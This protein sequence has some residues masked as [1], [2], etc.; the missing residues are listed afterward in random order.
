[1]T[2]SIVFVG[3]S[4]NDPDLANLMREVTARLQAKPP[5]H[6]AIMSYRTDAD[7]DATR[8]RMEGKFG[9]SPV[10]F[11]RMPTSPDGDDYSNLVPLLE[12]LAGR[13]LSSK[14]KLTKNPNSVAAEFDPEDPHKGRFG[15]L[16]E[17]SGRRVSVEKIRGS[18]AKGY[19]RVALTIAAVRGAPPIKGDVRFC[20]HPTFKPDVQVVAA[21]N[22]TATCSIKSFGAFTAGIEIVDEQRKFEIDMATLPHLPLWFRRQ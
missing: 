5:A 3:F 8:A 17:H 22:G 10:F 18:Q 4:M 21:N 9:V 14:T 6:Y 15:G 7:R 19:L 12:A 11:S 1:M 2:H 20:L 16:S 13:R